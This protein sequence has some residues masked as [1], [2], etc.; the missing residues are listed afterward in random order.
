[1]HSD[2]FRERL[3]GYRGWWGKMKSRPARLSVMALPIKSGNFEVLTVERLSFAE[4]GGSRQ[5]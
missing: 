5:D 1:M 3:R 4:K 2:N